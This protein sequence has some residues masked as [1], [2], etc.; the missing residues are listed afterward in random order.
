MFGCEDWLS[1]DIEWI[2][3]FK[4]PI[5]FVLELVIASLNFFSPIKIVIFPVCYYR[6]V[7]LFLVFLRAATVKAY[8][9]FFSWIF[10]I[11]FCVYFILLRI[12]SEPYI[13]SYT[14]LSRMNLKSRNLGQGFTLNVCFLSRFSWKDYEKIPVWNVYVYV[15][16]A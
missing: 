4:N 7:N 13:C 10:Q 3:S 5:H 15:V 11:P 12:L 8:K 16:S 14:N 9:E 2:S 1:G 6:M